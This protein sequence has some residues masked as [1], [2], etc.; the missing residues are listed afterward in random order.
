M[1]L[2]LPAEHSTSAGGAKRQMRDERSMI[3]PLDPQQQL[4]EPM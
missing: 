2:Q 4:N 1:L 3:W